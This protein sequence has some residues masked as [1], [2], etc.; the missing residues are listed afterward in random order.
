MSSNCRSGSGCYVSVN[1]YISKRIHDTGEYLSVRQR[2]KR[3]SPRK[4]RWNKLSS[5]RIAISFASSVY[6][7]KLNV[8]NMAAINPRLPISDEYMRNV[9]LYLTY[10]LRLTD[11]FIYSTLNHAFPWRSKNNDIFNSG[12]HQNWNR[13][14]LLIKA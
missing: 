2:L 13:G 12:R 4:M 7:I 9:T 1:L 10:F 14:T 6:D 5:H 11:I 8:R 3:K